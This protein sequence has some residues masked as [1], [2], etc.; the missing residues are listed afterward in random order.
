MKIR[1]RHLLALLS[2]LA[3]M[4]C[5]G[6]VVTSGGQNSP[7][8]DLRM[9]VVTHISPGRSEREYRMFVGIG[10]PADNPATKYLQREYTF[11]SSGDVRGSITWEGSDRVT[12]RVFEY[13]EDARSSSTEDRKSNGKLLAA[14]TYARSLG[15]QMF[16]EVN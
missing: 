12:L 9:A 11:K 2:T 16:R 5:A 3:V 14:Y 13:P 6:K 7:N 15:S 8:G 1:L 4:S 10:D